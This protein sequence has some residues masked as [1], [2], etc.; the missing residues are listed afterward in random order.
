MLRKRHSGITG[1][2]VTETLPEEPFVL[3]KTK[4]VH[5]RCRLPRRIPR[6]LLAFLAILL[7]GVIDA[8]LFGGIAEAA[9]R[10]LGAG[11]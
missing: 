7:G 10:A 4:N 2:G 1:R 3:I 8:A 11:S 6:K 5:F 9:R